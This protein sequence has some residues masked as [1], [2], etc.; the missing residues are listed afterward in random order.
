MTIALDCGHKV[1]VAITARN[2]YYMYTMNESASDLMAACPQG[3]GLR[4]QRK[5]TK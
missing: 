3:C 5:E 4:G 2:A 1:K